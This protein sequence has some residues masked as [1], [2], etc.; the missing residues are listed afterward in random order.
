MFLDYYLYAPKK[1]RFVMK[2]YYRSIRIA[3]LLAKFAVKNI[4]NTEKQELELLVKQTG[5]N[6]SDI[7]QNLSLET[8]EV[9]EKEAADRV[10]RSVQR[11]IVQSKI[12]YTR[13]VLRYAA[14]FVITATL[15]LSIY[16]M[17]S[18][19]SNKGDTIS[20]LTNE[21]VLE[22]PTGE[23]VVLADKTDISSLLEKSINHTPGAVETSAVEIYKVK[24]SSGATHT[25][26]LEDGT[27]VILYPESE[28][29]FP[30]HFSSLERS[31]TLT[32]EGYFDV[33]KDSSRLFTVN[34]DKASIVVYGTSFNV[35]AYS[36]EPTI[37]T[38][39]VSGKVTMNKTPLYPNQMA[40]LNREDLRVEIENVDAKI[41]L[42]R[43][44]GMF[45]FENRSLEEIMTEFSL[46]FGFEFHFKESTM[47]D[48][49]FR[50]RLPRSSNFNYLMDLME[51][52]GEVKFE[53]SDKRVVI[54]PGKE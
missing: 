20:L 44:S 21:T 36:N 7:I 10:W 51:K 28:L 42:E 26:I 17:N 25:I 39:L 49:R 13:V 19:K 37:E 32:G 31:V 47:R 1:R 6:V 34:T 35:R 18:W 45:I 12:N 3:Q 54:L 23:R 9:E 46:W 15:S 50:F 30:S 16:Y 8:N 4:S 40:I 29:H 24:V 11:G 27:T 22:Y 43:A 33:K 41:Y 5:I 52:T 14:L 2:R 53:V 38:T 48:K